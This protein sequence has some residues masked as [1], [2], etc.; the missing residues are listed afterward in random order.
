MAASSEPLPRYNIQRSYDWNYQHAPEP[1]TCVAAEVPGEWSFCGIRVP[2]PIGIPAGPLLNGRW[3]LYY[4]SLGFDV[5]T[6]K[7]V[8]SRERECYELPNLQHVATRQLD[9]TESELDTTEKATGSWAVSFGMPS[10]SPD[11]WMEDIRQTRRELSREKVLNVSVVASEQ[12]GWTIDDLADDYAQCA[13]LAIESGADTVET[14]FSCPNVSSCD[15]QLFQQPDDAAVVA[16]RVR[17][18]VGNTPYI[19]KLGHVNDLKLART[20][21]D[22]LGPHVDAF[23]MT[24]SVA[25]RVRHGEQLLFEGQRRGICGAATK[26]ASVAQTAMFRDLLRDSGHD[27]ELVG[28]GGVETACDVR[29]Y[30]DAGATSVQLATA[31]MLNPQVALE[32]RASLAEDA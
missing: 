29:D 14:N 8:R 10:R 25:T 13:S 18:A 9:G 3:L 27:V 12:P 30:I 6:Y 15:G 7:T 21:I 1:M 11:Q 2:S 19:A 26:S 16:R 31:A 17:E 28:V 23:A 5:L 4:A 22:S 20:I 32:L 24:N